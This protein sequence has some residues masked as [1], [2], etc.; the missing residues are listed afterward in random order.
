M[1]QSLVDAKPEQVVE[2]VTTNLLGSL[3]ATRA[4]IQVMGEQPTA[5]HIFNVDGAGADGAPTPQYA[6]YG[7]TKA[8]ACNGHSN[9]P[10][11]SWGCTRAR[12]QS[13]SLCKDRFLMFSCQTQMWDIAFEIDCRTLKYVS[14]CRHC[15]HDGQPEGGAA[16]GGQQRV[17][18][19]HLPRHGADRC[20]FVLLLHTWLGLVA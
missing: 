2:V 8:G 14:V 12:I 1:L 5:G 10:N 6:A 13:A 7:A 9:L 19:H 18:P 20:V 11:M 17:G 15:A 3:L 4:A 16:G